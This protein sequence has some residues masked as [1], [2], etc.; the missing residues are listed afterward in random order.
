MRAFAGA[1]RIA[2]ALVREQA[3]QT[4]GT[5]GGAAVHTQA[6]R[7]AHSAIES[8]LFKLETANRNE[9]AERQAIAE[10]DKAVREM[11]KSLGRN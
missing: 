2:S 10:I 9:P 6:I 8:A 1:F 7:N 3:G 11:K 4:S 5:P